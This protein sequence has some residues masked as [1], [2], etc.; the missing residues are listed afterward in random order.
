MGSTYRKGLVLSLGSVIQTTVDLHSVIPS[1]KPTGMNRMCP[2]HLQKLNQTH[3]CPEGGHEVSWDEFVLGKPGPGGGL[4]LAPTTDDKPQNEATSVLELKPIPASDIDDTTFDGPS[5]YYMQPY[6]A[7]I[8]AW[9]AIRSIIQKGKLALVAK[10]ALRRGSEKIWRVEVFRDYLVLRE[11]AFPEDIRDVP[12]PV[13]A[14]LEKGTL[15]LVDK[16]IENI[17]TTWDQIDTVDRS[18]ERLIAWIDSG[19]TVIEPTE[20]VDRTNEAAS[21]IEQLQQAVADS[22]K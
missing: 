12:A 21:L 14:K 15:T 16:F 1:S 4:V 9:L 6:D 8:Q 2:T 18:R 22:K 19:T 20:T 10:G 13:E 17:T 7:T 5:V 3:K 11:I